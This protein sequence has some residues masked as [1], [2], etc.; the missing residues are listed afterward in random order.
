[1]ETDGHVPARDWRWVLIWAGVILAVSCLPYLIAWV[2]TPSGYQFGGILVN[3]FDGNSYLAK[4]RQG[5]A[6]MWQFHLTYTPEP[7]D[8]A[9]IIYLFY[10]GLGHVARLMGLPL[11]LIYHAARVLAGLALLVAAY[12]FLVRLTH[13]AY[14]RRLGF[15]LV[16]ISA[17]LGWLGVAL[18]AFPI[19]LW[20]P[21]AFAFFSLLSNPHFPLAMALMLVVLMGVVWPASGVRRWLVP[22][23]AAL[24]LVLVHPLG[25]I[26]VYATLASYLVLRT[27]LDRKWPL[28]ELTAAIGV[29]LLSVP[30]LLY[31]YWIYVTNPAMSAWA[32]QNVTPAPQMFDLALGY[33]LIGLLAIL[34]GVV[35][36][37]KRDRGGL[38]LLTCAN[39]TEVDWPY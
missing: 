13:D 18:G 21:E 17:G 23:L 27:W 11:V 30:V 31:G 25:L 6:G 9:Y 2:A 8:G 33:G 34:G 1:M 28:A 36:V 32:A 12:A 22:G 14:E 39:V 35:A 26:P 37:R 20:V 15:W 7:H 19:D 38:A 3:P 16:G 29:G 24:V 4:M 5:W 10:L